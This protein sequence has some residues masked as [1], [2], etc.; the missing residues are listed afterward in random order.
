MAEVPLTPTPLAMVDVARVGARAFG[1]IARRLPP[2]GM[3]AIQCAIVAIENANGAAIIQYNWGN[4]AGEGPAG[5]WTHP[6]PQEGQPLHFQA[7]TSQDDG[8][9]AWWRLMLGRE[10]YRAVL[11]A[12]AN[13]DPARAVR[14][15]YAAGYVVPASPGEEQAYTKTVVDRFATAMRKWIPDA[16]VYSRAPLVIGGASLAGAL[17]IG[18]V[19]GYR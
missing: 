9:G 8:A 11:R 1:A 13:C 4:L 6:K 5:Y 3:L 17:G 15:L 18:F 10:G 14:A 2:R 19:R 16:G 12:G 7:R